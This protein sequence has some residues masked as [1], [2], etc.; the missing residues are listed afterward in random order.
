MHYIKG[1]SLWPLQTFDPKAEFAV[2]ERRLPHWSQAGAMCFLTW[3]TIDSIPA[4]TLRRWHAE[5]DEWLRK[6]EI[7]PRSPRWRQ[8][9]DQ[10]PRPLR[11][12]FARSFS[13]QWHEHLDSCHGDCLLRQPHL[14]KIV[15]D[16][17]RFGDGTL[18]DLEAFVVMP[19]HVHIL[20]AFADE[21]GMLD[22]CESWKHFT[23]VRIN[24]ITGKRGRFWQ[25]DGFDHLVRSIEHLEAFRRYIEL[26]SL[27]AKLKSGE[28]SLYLRSR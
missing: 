23:S 10:L 14:A 27:K 22:Q 18:Y 24:R 13:T 16:S 25:Q 21:Q 12:E 15:T 6:H 3:R 28:Y 17:L 20:A 7:D 11:A 19:N 2:V 5:R 9:F 1:M 8:A 4:N 26:N